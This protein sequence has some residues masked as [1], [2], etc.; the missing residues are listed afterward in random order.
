MYNL[1]KLNQL[2]PLTF[3]KMILS[4]SHYGHAVKIIIKISFLYKKIYI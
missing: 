4:L 2:E 1:F 3:L